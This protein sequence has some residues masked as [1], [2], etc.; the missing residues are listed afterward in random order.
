MQVGVHS[1]FEHRE[2][3]KFAEVG[4]LSVVVERTSN[5]YIEPAFSGLSRCLSEVRA[6]DGAELRADEDCCATVT[7]LIPIATLG[8]NHLSRPWIQGCEIHAVSFVGLLDARHLEVVKHHLSE[9]LAGL[10]FGFTYSSLADQLAICAYTNHTV[11]RKALNSKW[12]CHP[13]LLVVDIG[14]V[15]EVLKLGFSGDGPVNLLLP[16]DLCLPP[17]SV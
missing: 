6:L 4:S 9:D 15:I 17:I 5:Q 13:N 8:A 7:R 10:V 3:T 12:P 16:S 1:G 2:C 11:G 14:F